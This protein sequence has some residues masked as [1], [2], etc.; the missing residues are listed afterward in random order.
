MA[1]D[2]A[3]Q[4]VG[5]RAPPEP[6][7]ATGGSVVR[8]AATDVK[9]GGEWV[10]VYRA[11]DRAGNTIVFRLSANRGIATTQASVRKAIRGRQ[12]AART[13]TLVGYRAPYRAV[14][15]MIDFDARRPMA[16]EV[17]SLTGAPPRTGGPGVR[18]TQRN[19]GGT[20]P[21]VRP[22]QPSVQVDGISVSCYHLSETLMFPVAP[23]PFKCFHS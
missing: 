2:P 22:E 21:A 8:S 19:D 14:Q 15:E 11:V 20:R 17:A 12:S 16:V 3:R 23:R 18:P 1:N 5:V 9:V 6:L 4:C 7:R 10:G 13:V